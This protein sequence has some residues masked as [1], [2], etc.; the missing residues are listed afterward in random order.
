MDWSDQ[1]G[2]LAD[3]EDFA[4]GDDVLA[5]E[6]DPVRVRRRRGVRYVSAPVHW[7]LEAGSLPSKAVLVA[8]ELAFLS[9]VTRSTQVRFNPKCLRARISRF[10]VYRALN[11]LRK[12]GLIEF[13]R[14]RGKL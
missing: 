12:A 8:V 13:D 7:L 1:G 6:A 14:K 4:R 10:T 5:S 3:I 11:V 9:C 2:D